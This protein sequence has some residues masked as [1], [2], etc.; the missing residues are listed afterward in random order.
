MILL[1]TENQFVQTDL[2]I[3]TW[4]LRMRAKSLLFCFGI[5]LTAATQVSA[6][7]TYTYDTLGRLSCVLY[8]N[9][10]KIT[11]TYDPAGNRTQVVTQGG[12]ACP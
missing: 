9:G 7:T 2:A 3:S 4:R 11:Y 8:D 1:A 6:S 12:T 10:M 5:A